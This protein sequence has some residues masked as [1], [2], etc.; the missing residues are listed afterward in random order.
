MGRE[1]IQKW[2]REMGEEELLNMVKMV[3]CK[4]GPITEKDLEDLRLIDAEIRRRE[5]EKV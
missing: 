1:E 3:V 2:L 5:D 4:P